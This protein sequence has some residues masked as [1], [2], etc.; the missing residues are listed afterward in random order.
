MATTFATERSHIA[1]ILVAGW[2]DS[3]VNFPNDELAEL[4]GRQLPT[5]TGD[6]TAPARWLNVEINS[7]FT[8]QVAFSGADRIDG[9][10]LIEICVEAGVGDGKQR[11]MLDALIALFNAGDGNGV[12]FLTPNPGKPYYSPDPG[13][14]YIRPLEIPFVR[15]TDS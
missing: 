14:W 11:A 4:P 8:E 2:T 7:D 5:P 12:Q 6:R 15:F 3:Y 9:T 1:G 10:V 13:D